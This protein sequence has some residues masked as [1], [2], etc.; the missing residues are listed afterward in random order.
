MH[1]DLD[2]HPSR[3]SDGGP[4]TD[5]GAGFRARRRAQIRAARRRNM[6]IVLSLLGVVVGLVGIDL[7]R[8]ADGVLLDGPAATPAAAPGDGSPSGGPS[9][10]PQPSGR[11]ESTQA[12]APADPAGV[13]TAGTG[14]FAYVGGTGQPLGAKGTV[15]KFRVAVEQGT[16]QQ[17]NPFGGEVERILGDPR[18]WTAGG[19]YRFQRV[20]EKA[21]AEF[22]VYLASA[23]TSKKMCAAGGLYTDGFVSCRLPGQV[24]INLS[25]WLAGVPDYGAPLGDYRAFALNHEVGHQLGFGHE[26]CPGEGQDA[27]VMQQ[28]STGLKGCKANAWPYR[29]GL[30]Y[31]G[32][33]I[34]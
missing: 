20:A 29:S 34:P 16:D 9:A 23:E 3:R 14:K 22:T 18:G 33:A 1:S 8:G 7:A 26:A 24:I 32:P 10:A 2:T 31:R 11:E 28:Q 12:P 15:R 5:D 13:P 21:T 25:R 30:L 17:A 19:V 27:P 4:Q 6:I